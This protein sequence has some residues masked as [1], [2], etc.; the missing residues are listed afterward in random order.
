MRVIVRPALTASSA[1]ALQQSKQRLFVRLQLLQRLAL[2]PRDDPGDQPAR[3][4]HLD[5][6][7]ERA[8]LIKGGEGFAQVVRLRHGALHR[9]V[10]S[11][12]DAAISSP[13]AP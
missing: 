12:D 9:S 5:D 4:A 6:R 8:I 2:D 13:P 11:S 7:N 10:L 3:L 1:P